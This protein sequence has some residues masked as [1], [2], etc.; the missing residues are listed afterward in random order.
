MGLKPK[1]I[2]LAFAYELSDQSNNVVDFLRIP[3]HF[4][5]LQKP[6]QFLPSRFV[7]VFLAY[8]RPNP[9]RPIRPITTHTLRKLK[10]IRRIMQKIPPKNSL[11]IIEKQGCGSRDGDNETGL[12]ARSLRSRI[13]FR[14]RP[15]ILIPMSRSRPGSNGP[16][17]STHVFLDLAILAMV[18]N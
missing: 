13:R 18:Q 9:I 6:V 5:H 10:L 14:L 4:Y 8:F 15:G 3:L 16:P 11:V 12:R 1:G 17:F 7:L 2:C